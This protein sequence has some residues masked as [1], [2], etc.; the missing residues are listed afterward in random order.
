[1]GL[2]PAHL[3]QP[4]P[5][6]WK[7]N[8]LNCGS[9]LTGPFC[10]MCGQRAVPSH[11]TVKELAGDAAAEFSGWDGKFADTLRT[12][13]LKPGELTRQWIDGRRVR[14][15]SPL[16]LYL[17][18]SLLYFAVTASAPNI[19]T[20]ANGPNFALIRSDPAT[21]AGR[22]GERARTSIDLQEPLSPA[23]RDS[24]IADMRNAPAILLPMLYRAI[25]EPGAFKA[26]IMRALPKVFLALMPVLAAVFALFYRRRNYPEHLYFAIHLASFIFIARALGNLALFTGVVVFAAVA[27]VAMTI[28]I[29]VYGVKAMRRVYGGTITMTILKGIGICALYALVA[30]P[31]VGI[32]AF[33]AAS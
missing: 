8:C 1:M 26:A 16:R 3:A 11:P 25:E 6:A 21:A 32:V 30:L 2:T 9:Q 29:L 20:D 15:I 10:G 31:I 14:F 18:A 22:T 33:L 17:S 19:R 7:A 24:A 27:Q 12:L 4:S 28:W 13:F 5:D 23:E